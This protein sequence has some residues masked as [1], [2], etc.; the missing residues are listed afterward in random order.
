MQAP[1]SLLA[2]YHVMNVRTAG[3]ACA[4]R[5]ARLPTCLWEGALR[6]GHSLD[7]PDISSQAGKGLTVW[8]DL[9]ESQLVA[10]SGDALVRCISVP[11]QCLL[12]SHGRLGP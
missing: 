9:Q 5:P 3:P 2:A 6:D 7:P 4:G 1:V 12:N 8:T 11:E 10:Q